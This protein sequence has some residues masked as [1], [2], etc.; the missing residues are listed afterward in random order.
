MHTQSLVKKIF[1]IIP[2]IKKGIWK[3]SFIALIFELIKFVPVILIKLIIDMLVV[4]QGSTTQVIYFIMGVFLSY[5]A[6]TFIDYYAKRVE[7]FWMLQYETSILKKAK[8]KLLDLHL[9]YHESFSTGMQVSKITKGAHKLS[10]LLWFTFNEFIPTIIQ[11]LLTVLLL[12]YEQWILAAIFALFLP[13]IL[14]ITLSTYR[15]LQPLRK[16]YH[17][18]YD[19][20]V[21]ELGESLLNI[22][23]VKD[24]VQE[25]QQF[26]KFEHLLDQYERNARKR[27]YFAQGKLLWRDLLI[28]AGRALTLGIASFMVVKGTLT[29]GSLVLVYTLTERAFL[30]T[31][32]IGRLYSY[33]GDAMESINRLTDLLRREPQLQDHPEA[34]PVKHLTGEVTF[35]TVSFSYGHGPHVLRDIKLHIKP[36]QVIALVGKSGSGKSTIAKLLLRNYDVTRGKITGNGIDIRSYKIAQYKKR[37]A[38]VSQNVEVFNRRVIEN[39]LFANPQATRKEAIS[40]AKKAHAH[41]FIKDFPKG[42]DTLVGEK[43]VRLSG[44]QKQRLSIARALLRDP[45]I[46][47]FDEATSSLDS[48]SERFIQ[49][50]IFSI[51][52]KKTTIIIAHRLSTIKHADVIVVMDNGKIVERGTYAQLVKKQGLF[53]RMINLQD[54]GF[55]A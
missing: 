35:D 26:R 1:E 40:A 25:K 6:L 31:F 42:Y 34:K 50:S 9:G 7:F 55:R 30:S 39:I 16:K 38:V 47:I 12:L 28:T 48:E 44:G 51:A 33:L 23:T 27:W 53:A 17:Q 8:Q 11:L 4:D 18:N 10:E 45:D 19:D 41:E 32:R 13:L 54:I 29:A 2:E 15:K 46:F 37:L 36:R 14:G 22:S 20:A 24:Y 3:A 5:L 52:G 49:K 21:G 43:G